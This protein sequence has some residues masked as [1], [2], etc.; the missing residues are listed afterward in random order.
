MRANTQKCTKGAG[1]KRNGRGKD[2][3]VGNRDMRISVRERD[4]VENMG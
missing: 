3:T 4:G 2:K 1:D